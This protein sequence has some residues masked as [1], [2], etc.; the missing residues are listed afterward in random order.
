MA[1]LIASKPDVT[2]SD[3]FSIQWLMSVLA[4]E[5]QIILQF[6]SLYVALDIGSPFFF[7]LC[8][9]LAS[10]KSKSSDTRLSTAN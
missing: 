5:K 9:S 7:I 4:K 8:T 6:V 2:K 10:S 1:K 3:Y